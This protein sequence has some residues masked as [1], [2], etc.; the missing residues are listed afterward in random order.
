MA[1]SGEGPPEDGVFD[2]LTELCS[3]TAS[4]YCS[5]NRISQ[6]RLTN[7]MRTHAYEIILKKT[8]KEIPTSDND[9]VVDLLSFYLV[10]HQNAKN[11]A[12]YKR[13]VELKKAISTIRRHDF[14]ENKDNIDSVLKFLV[15][16]S[17]SVKEDLSPEM[18]KSPFSFGL[19]NEMLPKPPREVF[20]SPQP[21]PYFPS[22][23]FDLPYSLRRQG[24]MLDSQISQT[25]T[26]YTVE[27]F[28]SR[29]LLADTASQQKSEVKTFLSPMSLASMTSTH[30][31]P[32]SESLVNYTRLTG[33]RDLQIPSSPHTEANIKV[34]FTSTN[35]KLDMK[36]VF[37]AKTDDES[38]D[39]WELATQIDKDVPNDI[40]EIVSKLPPITER[41]LIASSSR[42]LGLWKRI[43]ADKMDSLKV[44]SERQ[45][46][47]HIMYLIIG[48]ETS[49]FPY[50][51]ETDPLSLA[52]VGV[53]TS[54]F[55][56]NEE[57]DALSLSEGVVLEGVSRPRLCRYSAALAHAVGVE[58]S[59]FPYNEETD[60]LSLAEGV[61]L[62][63]VS[64]PRLRRYSAALARAVGVE[65]SSFPYNEETDALSLAEGV[66]LDGVSRSRL[67]R[68]SAPLALLCFGV[69][70]SSFPY[71]EETDALSLAEGVVLE[72]VSKPRLRR[73]SSAALARA[74][75]VE[76]SSF[77][78]NEETD[79][80]SLAEGVVL[81][82]VSKPRL[83]R[84]SAAL[85]RAVGVET[86]SFPYN[87][88]TDALS[89]AE[90][91]V[92]EGVSRPRLRRYSA[93]LALLC[94][95]VE[96]SSFL[97]NEETDA[98]SFAEG[99][100]LEGVSRPRLRRYSAALARAGSHYRR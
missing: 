76:T 11:V 39:I 42:E 36:E 44:V 77:P 38:L 21:Y 33:P 26:E 80:L 49:S 85:A 4:K 46:I 28:D 91:V 93:A 20:G 67:R 59:S 68:Y 74:V 86:S 100:V 72:G 88:E 81:E 73:Y 9:P 19:F 99:V 35:E 95:G 32:Y 58:T 7:K 18:Y 55:P 51:E 25:Y 52:E 30:L 48:V 2:L 3:N 79:A 13:C 15:G 63:G 34:S 87:E 50:N 94:F 12:E 40:W 96:T 64:K 71:N 78:Y 61:V 57:T 65:T 41:Q 27:S 82:G 14:G 98:L 69:E 70:T 8:T 53:E 84:Y 23:V 89:L 97:Y 66:V 75:G 17:N 31:S 54:S 62:E 1:S 83:R 92:L 10:S 56:Y 29:A 43:Y 37:R 90:G 22:H 16:L 45:F 47:R 6:K 24:R 60:A 5:H